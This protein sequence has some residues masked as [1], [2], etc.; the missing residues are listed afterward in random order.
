MAIKPITLRKPNTHLPPTY[1][2]FPHSH[3]SHDQFDDFS[4]ST[5]SDSEMLHNPIHHST[6]IPQT[7]PRIA[8]SP[9]GL[10]KPSYASRSPISV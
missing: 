5:H 7:L 6:S 3:L 4:N 10:L 1:Q 9:E 2:N 8:D